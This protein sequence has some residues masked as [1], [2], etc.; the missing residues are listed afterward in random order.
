MHEHQ[1]EFYDGALG[2][3]SMVCKHCGVDINDLEEK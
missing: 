2:Y 3:E 1:W